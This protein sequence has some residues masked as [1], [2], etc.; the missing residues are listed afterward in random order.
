MEE[1]SIE[2]KELLV[3]SQVRAVMNV[4]VI[5]SARSRHNLPAVSGSFRWPCIKLQIQK[6]SK[7]SYRSGWLQ[8][9]L[10]LHRPNDDRERLLQVML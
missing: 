7:A 3:C 1:T 5:S 8:P 2:V 4:H 6:H 10:L 9:T